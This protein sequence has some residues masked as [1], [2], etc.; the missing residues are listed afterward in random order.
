MILGKNVK[1]GEGSVKA[2]ACQDEPIVTVLIPTFNRAHLLPEC[3]ESILAQTYPYLEIIIINDGSSDKTSEVVKPYLDRITYIE[4]VN[5]GKASAVN[6]G[7]KYARGEFI[8]IM[9]DDDLA[10]PNALEQHLEVFNKDPSADFT[11]SGY[12]FETPD[13]SESKRK[14]VIYRPAF[15]GTKNN[16][17]LSFMFGASYPEE[18]LILLHF[19]WPL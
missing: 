18:G 4:K 6:R 5:G 14:K 11:Y 19:S 13:L 17:F 10:L 1:Y 16:L 12:Y 3:L 2:T 15:K 9:D 7:L 8:W